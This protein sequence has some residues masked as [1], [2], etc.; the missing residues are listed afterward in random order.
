[1][2]FTQ[3]IFD[4]CK[5]IDD[6][7]IRYEN[8]RYKISKCKECGSLCL[9]SF[10]SKNGKYCNSSCANKSRMIGNTISKG[11]K[12]SKS[13]KEKI[14]I[15]LIGNTRTKGRIIPEEELE[16][17]RGR[18]QSE[19]QKEKTRLRMMGNAYSVGVNV[20][21]NHPQWKGGISKEPYCCMWTKEYKE[22]IK[23]RDGYKCLNPHCW[24]KD[25]GLTIHHLD[26]NKKNC[27]P[28]NLIT[29]CRSCNSR[30]NKNENSWMA[31][32]QLIL[33]QRYGY[34][35]LDGGISL[36][37]IIDRNIK[38]KNIKRTTVHGNSKLTIEQVLE[39]R[40]KS[41]DGE[42][43]KT[44]EEEYEISSANISNIINLKTWS[45]LK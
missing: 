30:A 19:K 9:I 14:S 35:Y 21:P 4:N 1:M 3:E 31:L 23:E 34:Q 10:R 15:S 28:K 42:K 20:G 16:R 39:I 6:Y 8:S 38:I 13:H 27:H 37:Y 25:Y 17:R 18:K 36:D 43:L 41:L 33:N 11:R 7:I 26:Y 22:E 44:L 29:L 40:Q 5:W 2:K 24:N 45:W 32:Y 12:L